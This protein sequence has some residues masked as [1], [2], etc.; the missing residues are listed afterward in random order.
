M[1]LLAP[2]DRALKLWLRTI[3]R[4]LHRYPELSHQE[5]QT[6]ALIRE[7]LAELGISAEQAG[8]TGVI[9]R[10][11]PKQSKKAAVALRA[12]IDA[13]PIQE[14][15]GLSFASQKPGVMHACGHDGHTAMLLGAAA[16]LKRQ[17]R[18]P[19]RVVLIFQPAEEGDGGAQGMI[20]AGAL[21]GVGSIFAGHLDRLYPPGR[22]AIQA[23]IICA[24]TDDFT[25]DLSG[26]GGHA[27]K[28]HETSDPVVAAAAL[29]MNLQTLVARSINP[30]RPAAVTV[31]QINGGSAANVIATQV[32]LTGTIRTTDP[33]TREIIHAGLG[34]MVRATATMH[35]LKGKLSIKE[36]CPPLI[37]DQA[38]TELARQVA[39]QQLGAANVSGLPEPS[40][41]GEDFSFYLARVPGCMVRFGGRKEGCE[42]EPAHSPGFD[43]DEATLPIGAAFLANLALAALK[44]ENLCSSK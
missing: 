29:V 17:P 20:A 11:G 3:R 5:H 10:L 23:G 6:C 37:N 8:P 9:A 7:K 16:L 19:G 41:G 1:N 14:K 4:R 26:R 33:H 40:L 34:R 28:P 21:E 38:A 31:G 27:A 24:A 15:T 18:L 25:I 36:G 35:Q 44:R 22:I 32:R 12:D 43:F 30:A 42:N 39:E 13:L 2:P